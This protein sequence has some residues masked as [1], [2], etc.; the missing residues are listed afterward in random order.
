M[1]VRCP[2]CRLKVVLPDAPPKEPIRCPRC[3][4]RLIEAGAPLE[5]VQAL[6]I[7]ASARRSGGKYDELFES[8]LS[9]ARQYEP[10]AYTA[11][12]EP[13]RRSSLSP[14]VA[15]TATTAPAAAAKAAEPEEERFGERTPG[16]TGQV[17]LVI[18]SII[19]VAAAGYLAFYYIRSSIRNEDARTALQK[20]GRSVDPVRN[21]FRQAEQYRNGKDYPRAVDA[22]KAVVA[23]A[24]P[25]LENLRQNTTSVKPGPITQQADALNA[26]LADYIRKA[27]TALADPEVKFSAQGLTEFF[28]GEWMTP[29]TKKT[30]FEARMAAEGRRLHEGEW[31]TEA[32]IHE[33]KGEVFYDGRW[34]SK[35]EYARLAQATGAVTQTPPATLP[36]PVTRVPRPDPG[37]YDPSVNTWVL[38]DFQDNALAWTNVRW[39]DSNPCTLSVMKFQESRQLAINLTGGPQIKSTL[40]R[41]MGLDLSSRTTL[42]MDVFNGCGE[43][44]RMAIAVE[45]GA[46]PPFYESRWA[47]LRVDANT[48]VTFDLKAG[49]FKCA[50]HWA[51]AARIQSPE[52]VVWLYII[53][54]HN[55]PGKVYVDN[56]VALNGK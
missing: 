18:L 7:G 48:G 32:E 56:I 2:G 26:E 39:A 8:L 37:K 13:R 20:I 29:E 42:S 23:Q 28:E 50:P 12:A 51:H 53:V 16:R 46:N 19:F 22:Y 17:L 35:A 30:R 36:P 55:K 44:I 15:S 3:K 11:P 10:R 40:V 31:L 52:K 25:L 5:S 6:A 4:L 43:P 9:E 38:D 41:P 21:L 34:V 1:L 45:T 47:T 27:E 14:S 54:Y 33:R 24:S 49:D